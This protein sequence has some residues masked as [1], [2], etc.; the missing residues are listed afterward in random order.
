M[1]N[2]HMLLNLQSYDKN[3]KHHD[4]MFKQASG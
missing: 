4:H 1:L 2:S 3:E